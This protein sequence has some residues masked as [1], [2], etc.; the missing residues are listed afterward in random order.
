MTKSVIVDAGFLV[1][2]LSGRDGNHRCAKEQDRLR[3]A[4]FSL[5]FRHSCGEHSF[6]N[7]F[8]MR[9]IRRVI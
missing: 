9:Q 4:T 7:S 8:T 2:L 3:Q 6:A 5:F 1:A